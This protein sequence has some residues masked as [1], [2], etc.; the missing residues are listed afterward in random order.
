M[1]RGQDRPRAA[2]GRRLRVVATH[3]VQKLLVPMLYPLTA[4]AVTQRGSLELWGRF[5]AIQLVVH[6]AAHIIGWG[7]R[8]DVLRELARRPGA[9]AAIWQSSLLTRS[10]L[11]PLA[12]WALWL[13]APSPAAAVAA[14]LF[15]AG[16]V[17]YQ[18]FDPL[19]IRRRA[20]GFAA[21]LDLFGLAVLLAAVL[22][23]PEPPTVV[24][25]LGWFAAVHL[26]KVLL[27]GWRLRLRAL[28][29]F[30]ARFE[31]V[32]WRRSLP[33]FLLGLS[34]L[35]QSRIDLYCVAAYLPAAEL[36]G[37]QV[38]SNV[39]LYLQSFAALA[40]AP[41]VPALYRASD[42]TLSKIAGRLFVV[43]LLLTP[44]AIAACRWLLT[45]FFDFRL[46]PSVW[47]AAACTVPPVYFYLP[48][49]Y[50]LFKAGRQTTVVTVNAVGALLNLLLNLL[51][52]PTFGLLGA[53][54][55]TALVQWAGLLAY[56]G[57][58]GRDLACQVG[59]EKGD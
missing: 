1:S 58:A 34:G 27:L 55:A 7:N 13:L 15:C 25:L 59:V 57:L 42:R 9:L 44:P 31:P 17:L 11:L 46:P 5:V 18:S 54:V 12:F 41:F 10:T 39:L 3:S 4:A 33:F 38:L 37:Y 48:T 36:G 29:P 28:Q 26:G 45:G 52:L 51:L 21:A 20:F 23:N 2:T 8:D 16:L 49:I 47:L 35:L 43:G 6:L 30:A 19:V 14:S 32:I 40:L 24:G 22:S 50:A 53:L 56:R